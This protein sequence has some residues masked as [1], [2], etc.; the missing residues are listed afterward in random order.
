[1][2]RY[3]RASILRLDPATGRFDRW[4][5]E[6]RPCCLA[7]REAGGLVVAFDKGFGRFDPR[8]AAITWIADSEKENPR[9]RIND[10]KVD[11]H[12][13]F[14]VGTLD[15]ELK[16]HLGALYR[17]D[18]D[19]TVTQLDAGFGISNGPAWSPD[20]RTFYFG[21]RWT[22][23]SMPTTTMRRAAPSRTSE[24][25]PRSTM[26]RASPT[27]PEAV[28]AEGCLWNAPV[29]CLARRPLPT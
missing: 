15:D 1:M 13:R 27:A 11:R 10:G 4:P 24:F 26:A 9:T 23:R 7:E 22:R 29:G 25:S 3:H 5:T 19:G 28:D 17:L 16:E 12:G 6:M 14:V 8:S 18:A 21:D 20:D 2:G